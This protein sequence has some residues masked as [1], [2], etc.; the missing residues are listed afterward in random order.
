MSIESNGHSEEIVFIIMILSYLVNV[1]SCYSIKI[2][3]GYCFEN[4]V[5]L[6]NFLHFHTPN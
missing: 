3:E 5:S 4:K 6:R 2:V 1:E